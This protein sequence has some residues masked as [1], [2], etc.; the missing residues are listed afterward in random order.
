MLE[1]FKNLGFFVA[2]VAAL[3]LANTAWSQQDD[4]EEDEEEEEMEQV[5]VTGSRLSQDL[6]ELAGQVI[7]MT[8]DD[9][10]ATGEV[11]LERVLRQLPENLNPTTERYGS[12]LNRL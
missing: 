10:R 12:N 5:V 2:L 9:I 11:T 3:I 1:H 4:D 7:I 6:G 8:A